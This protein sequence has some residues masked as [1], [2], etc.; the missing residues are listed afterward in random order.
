MK[1][2]AANKVMLDAQTLWLN[3]VVECDNTGVVIAVSTLENQLSEP[4]STF[5]F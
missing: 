3:A 2:F 4:A 5:F 1:R